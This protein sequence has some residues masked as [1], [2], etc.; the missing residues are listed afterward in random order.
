MNMQ[1]IAFSATDLDIVKSIKQNSHAEVYKWL[2]ANAVST[3]AGLSAAWQ[4]EGAADAQTRHHM[5]AGALKLWSDSVGPM[6]EVGDRFKL[7]A[8]IDGMSV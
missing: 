5:A 2:T 3:I 4:P 7:Q 8:L 1:Q 6:E